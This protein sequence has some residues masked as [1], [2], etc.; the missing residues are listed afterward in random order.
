MADVARLPEIILRIGN[1]LLSLRK[2]NEEYRE[3]HWEVERTDLLA[4]ILVSK[5]W[6]RTLL[7]LLW[8]VYD[9]QAPYANSLRTEY[10]KDKSRYF[11]YLYLKHP[12]RPSQSFISQ[13]LC[14]ALVSYRALRSWPTL[15][16]DNPG[17]KDL[18]LVDI[19]LFTSERGIH[20]PARLPNL[21]HLTLQECNSRIQELFSKFLSDI[22]ISNLQEMTFDKVIS[23][24][25]SL[26]WPSFPNLT[27]LNVTGATLLDCQ[28][29][30]AIVR[31]SPRLETFH[32]QP[33]YPR[34][35]KEVVN[36]LRKNLQECCPAL[37][38]IE[39]V[40]NGR[41]GYLLNVGDGDFEVGDN[42]ELVTDNDF[43]MLLT[44]PARLVHVAWAARRLTSYV[45]RL[46]TSSHN[47]NLNSSF[48]GGG[49]SGSLETVELIL[50]SATVQSFQQVQTILTKCLNLRSFSLTCERYPLIRKD[51]HGLFKE[52][53]KCPKLE[54]LS[55]KRC[56][57]PYETP[58][59]PGTT[60]RIVVSTTTRRENRNR[61][62]RR[63]EDGEEEHD[64]AAAPWAAQE[65][66]L[67]FLEMVQDG[68]WTL[69]QSPPQASST[70]NAKMYQAMDFWRALL[71]ERHSMPCL[72]RIV[73]EDHIYIHSP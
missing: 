51:W 3:S 47:L 54:H 45:T 41:L 43:T 58:H 11:R 15:L 63:Q 42:E 61:H 68:G 39:C 20:I 10:I 27:R 69:T 19:N 53:S 29:I 40:G 31:Q 71:D 64:E 9:G 57:D 4:C 21:T 37:K 34:E 23:W 50:Y 13:G 35:Q 17:I 72:K 44:A 73:V 24:E 1:Y 60:H 2:S 6:Y 67:E 55:L 52:P 5:T 26:G 38:R 30:I 25:T 66:R 46:L 14:H 16:Q 22:A 7:P 28:A 36:L 32:F 8:T 49:A 48:V 33:N 56:I 62:F 18:T 65:E 70:S 12:P 59:W